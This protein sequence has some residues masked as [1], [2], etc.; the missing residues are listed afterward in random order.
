MS[1][2]IPTP[3]P[4][5][6]CQ[7]ALQQRVQTAY[8]QRQPQPL[9]IIGGDSK[10]FYGREA[11]G[12][13]LHAGA[14]CGVLDYDPSELVI[15]ARAGTRMHAVQQLLAAEQQMLGFEPPR[16]SAT[17]TVGGA[18][19]AGLSG[20]RRPYA[21]AVRDFVLGVKIINGKGEVMRFGGQVMKNVAGFDIARLMVGAMGTLGVLLE[22]SLRVMPQP[23][24]ETTCRFAHRQP[25]QAIALFN[26]LAARPLPLSAAAWSD[27]TT[28]LRW[29]GNQAAVRNAVQSIGGEEESDAAGRAFWRQLRDHDLPFFGGEQPLLRYAVRAGTEVEVEVE[30]RKTNANADTNANAAQLLDWGG[31]QRWLRGAINLDELRKIA[32]AHGGHVTHFRHGDRQGEVFQSL[33][34]PLHALHRRLKRAFDPAGILNPSRLYAD[35]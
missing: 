11:V 5:A 31:A 21:G 16:F 6:D 22:V 14:H 13:P 30:P 7:Q 8:A 28:R 35:L 23:Q 26:Q 19:A 34:A 32:A 20:P 25:Q 18:V 27:G 29:S 2:S 4:E 33:S 1:M 9:C 10:A 24:A 17:T 3:T 15:T 12:E